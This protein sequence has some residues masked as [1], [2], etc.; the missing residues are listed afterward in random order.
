MTRFGGHLNAR[1]RAAEE[2]AIGVKA[3]SR[4]CR[5]SR[6]TTQSSYPRYNSAVETR[7]VLRRVGGSIVV[8]IP[9]EMLDE[10]GL[11]EGASVVLRSREGRIEL[12]REDLSSGFL[13]WVHRNLDKYDE[14]YRDLADR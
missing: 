1:C 7:R 9:P 5:T 10:S 6:L 4:I 12:E 3:P 11:G 8:A 13:Q 2:A 14:A